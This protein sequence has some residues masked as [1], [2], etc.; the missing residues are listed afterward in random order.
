[1]RYGDGGGVDQQERARR[2]RVRR[3]AA[4]LFALG[5]SAVEVAG[6]LE[7]STKSAYQWRRVWVAGGVE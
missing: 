5:R 4:Q 7:V 3:Q 1:M 6:L 2:E